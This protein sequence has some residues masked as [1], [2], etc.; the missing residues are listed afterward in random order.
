[1]S[2]YNILPLALGTDY[3]VLAKQSGLLIP[4]L[5]RTDG[6]GGRFVLDA[7]L[8]GDPVLMGIYLDAGR[9]SL[10]A[11]LLGEYQTA[12]PIEINTGRFVID[13]D[14][15]ECA[16][17]RSLSFPVPPTTLNIEP[18]NPT[19]QATVTIDGIPVLTV[20]PVS[21]WHSWR[22]NPELAQRVYTFTLTGS[23]DVVIPV[24][25]IQARLRDGAPTFISVVVPS[26]DYAGD[27]AARSSG[28][29]IIKRGN[30]FPNGTMQLE[31]I[32]RA[33]LNEIRTDEGPNNQ[34]I[35]LTGR[36]TQSNT[37][38]KQ[39]VMENI[40]Y[41]AENKG[42]RRY[43]C[44]VDNFLRPGDTAVIGSESIVVGHMSWYVNTNEE[45]MEIV[46]AG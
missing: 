39:V 23:P 26:M 17:N 36:T 8:Y 11:E 19:A 45:S 4:P 18:I 44:S 24:T 10:D 32:G 6:R 30:R 14:F 13:C 12:P 41:R 3:Y 21:L 20:T 38:P 40:Q 22:I 34:S 29:M 31:E 33:T 1:M 35:T 9:F 37:A 43:R 25:S 16:I 27:I 15:F 7:S 46:E 2:Q 42:I 28:E 5:R